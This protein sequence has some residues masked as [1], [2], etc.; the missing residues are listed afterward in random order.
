MSIEFLL[1]KIIDGHKIMGVDS[2]NF[3]IKT[4]CICGS[5]LK[6]Q[7]SGEEASGIC[8]SC[9]EY[10]E[11]V[12]NDSKFE[13]TK[14][15]LIEKINN[16]YYNMLYYADKRGL[17]VHPK[18]L[19][20]KAE[21]EKWSMEN[22]CSMLSTFK[23]LSRSRGYLPDYCKWTTGLQ[24]DT[25]YNEN[26]ADSV[27]EIGNDILV[28]RA[29]T[30][31]ISRHKIMAALEEGE[32]KHI[33]SD[34][35]NSLESIKDLKGEAR[36]NAVIRMYRKKLSILSKILTETVVAIVACQLAAGSALPNNNKSI[37]AYIRRL[38]SIITNG[39]K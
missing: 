22:G 4:T 34:A 16:A 28:I 38:A 32:S 35:L 12:I 1:G 18:W 7:I 39:G 24:N 36:D 3:I 6:I 9:G 13:D 14:K 2:R 10:V 31:G 29:E 11:L 26:K 23:R 19:E 37:L 21:F 8:G 20:S 25:D 17:T 5:V 15:E 33:L 27:K 30:F